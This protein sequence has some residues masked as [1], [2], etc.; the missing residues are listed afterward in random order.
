MECRNKGDVMNEDSFTLDGAVA[1]AA[2]IRRFWMDRGHNISAWV[3]PITLGNREK[4]L[5]YYQVR[6]DLINA[7]PPA[8]NRFGGA[9]VVAS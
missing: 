1:M 4:P 8:R 3:E 9:V 5:T 6:S 2:K 7:L